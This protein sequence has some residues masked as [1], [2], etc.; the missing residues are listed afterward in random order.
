MRAETMRLRRNVRALTA[1][2]ALAA[3][4]L[5]LSASAAQ[6]LPGGFWG[7]VP[8]AVPSLEQFQ[9]LRQGGVESVRVPIT[10]TVVQATRGASFNWNGIDTE[11]E[12]A[13]I[14]GI[15]VFPF[16]SGVPTWTG[17]PSVSVPG[18]G[19]SVK[20]PAH[21][22][23]SG[24]ARSGWVAFVQ[25]AIGRYGPNGSFWAE[26]PNVPKLPVR[27]WQIWN[28]ENFVYFVTKPN[29][30]EYGKLVGISYGAVKAVDPGAKVVLGGMFARPKGGRSKAKPKRNYFA[31]DF[32][33]QMYRTTP[34]VKAKFNGVA[35]HPYSYNYQELP[36]E[37]DELRTV[38]AK[39]HDGGKGLWI[40]ELGWSS[41]PPTRTDLFAKGAGGQAA[42]L[43][44]AF[45][46]FK[47]FQARWR[48]KGVYWFSVDDFG[49]ACNFCD[50]SGLFGAGFKPKRSWFEYVKFAGGTP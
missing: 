18:S 31:A 50:G 23:V 39:G 35:L 37:I 27:T 26:H 3:S 33:Q 32:L 21:L 20:A 6:A 28:E 17:V 41:Q 15:Q 19:G 12:E 47:R 42:Q 34:G 4:A 9:R 16:L 44:G 25:A 8:Q 40:T 5:A 11:V 36:G 45:G 30:A 22:P 24:V 13:S 29:P 2:F 43:R 14:A 38:M 7:V 46:L 1:A 48:L 49:G 10:W